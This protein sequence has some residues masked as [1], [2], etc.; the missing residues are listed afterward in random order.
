[1]TPGAPASPAVATPLTVLDA[2]VVINLDAS[3]QMAAILAVVPGPVAVADRVLAET[4]FDPHA[5]PHPTGVPAERTALRALIASGRL[6]VLSPQTDDELE[7]FVDLTVD[8]D[9]GEAMTLALAIHRGYTVATDEHRAIRA[10]AGRAR[11]ISTLHLVKAW[12]DHHQI[13]APTLRQAL[14][15]IRQRGSYVPSKNHPLKPWWDAAT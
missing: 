4:R 13:D 2:C 15:D 1:M 8:L 9:D 11:L 6:S 5:T 14:N 12:A 10:L 3:G 7:T